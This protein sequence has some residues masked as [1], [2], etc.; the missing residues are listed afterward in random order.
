M[1]IQTEK[2]LLIEELTKIQD[3]QVIEQIKQLLKRD[4]PVV[5]Y[6]VNG[7]PITR[8]QLI[9]RI[10]AAEKRMDNGEFITQEEL[11]KEAKN[12]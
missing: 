9:K 4:N 11:E 6:A 7:N 2:L 12:W 8:E 5:G 3:V 10:A 1:D